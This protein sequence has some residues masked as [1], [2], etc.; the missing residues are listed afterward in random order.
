MKSTI[1]YPS[2]NNSKL[3]KITTRHRAF[4]ASRRR[5]ELPRSANDT[6]VPAPGRVPRLYCS[7]ELENASWAKI[8]RY[9]ILKQKH[10]QTRNNG[11]V[12]L[13]SATEFQLTR[14]DAAAID[15]DKIHTKFQ[16]L[17]MSVSVDCLELLITDSQ[18]QS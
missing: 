12:L 8:A 18:K 15:D 4:R 2:Q 3:W 10:R 14:R 16:C 17:N 11:M 1:H 5:A 6:Q 7:I 13:N 9:E